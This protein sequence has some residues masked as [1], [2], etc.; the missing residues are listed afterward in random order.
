MKIVH[1]MTLQKNK[2]E[3][4]YEISD[5]LEENKYCIN[6]KE[7]IEELYKREVIGST[8]IEEDI[9]LPHVESTSILESTIVIVHSKEGIE[10]DNYKVQIIIFLFVK[11]DERIEV[12]KEI[13]GFIR[14]LVSEKVL[15]ELRKGKY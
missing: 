3:V 14:S 4:F 6:H 9:A 11:K 15:E 7:I 12:R 10:W 2:E 13:Q 8:L 1:R 5:Y